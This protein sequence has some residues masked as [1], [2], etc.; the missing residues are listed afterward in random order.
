MLPVLAS[1]PNLDISLKL[2]HIRALVVINLAHRFNDRSMELFLCD[3]PCWA[4]NF[5]I[6]FHEPA[7]A[8]PHNRFLSSVIPVRPPVDI[9]TVSAIHNARQCVFPTVDSS[10]PCPGLEISPP[11]HFL[12]DFIIDLFGYYRLVASF[13][14]VLR[15]NTCIS[16]P[17]FIEKI[18]GHCLLQQRV[19]NILF[20]S[21]N[22][23]DR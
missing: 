19:T 15:D 13:H 1:N 5:T 7:D 17:L 14:I 16:H 11:R 22:V 8:P 2:R 10:L 23:P 20:I 21:Q 6:L 4:F 18:D 9:T 3:R 12:L